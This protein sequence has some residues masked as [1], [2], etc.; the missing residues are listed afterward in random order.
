[1]RERTGFSL[2]GY[3]FGGLQLLEVPRRDMKGP[4]H[5]GGKEES[6]ERQIIPDQQV[7]DL[8]SKELT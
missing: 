7:T 5:E 4:L 8:I 2:P 3:Q 1:M 6:E